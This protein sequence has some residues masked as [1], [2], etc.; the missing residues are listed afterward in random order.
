MDTTPPWERKKTRDALVDLAL[1]VGELS[2]SIYDLHAAV[3]QLSVAVTS[4]A[5]K[6][7]QLQALFVANGYLAKSGERHADAYGRLIKVLEG[8]AGDG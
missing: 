5:E 3:G 8:M 1:I 2:S 7:D 6:A 4:G